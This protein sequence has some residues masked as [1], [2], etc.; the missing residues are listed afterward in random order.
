MENVNCVLCP[1][2]KYLV[3]A[4]VCM[5]SVLKNANIKAKVRFFIL[6][7]ELEKE[8]IKL[9]NELKKIRECEINIINVTEYFGY[10]K[11]VDFTDAL[12]YLKGN[13]ETLYRLLIWKI[14]PKDVEK[15]FYLDS[16]LLVNCD[17]LEVSKK[18]P[19]DKLIAAVEDIYVITVGKDIFVKQFP[20]YEKTEEFKNFAGDVKGYN[21]FG[22][23]FLLVNLKLGTEMQIFEE[24]VKYLNKYPNIA[25]M[26]QDVLNI[27]FS[28]N[29]KDKV[30]WLDIKYNYHV[31]CNITVMRSKN[32]ALTLEKTKVIHFAG[33]SKPW[34]IG[35]M[36][37]KEKDYLHQY[38]REWFKYLKVSPL[39]NKYNYYASKK[40]I[41]EKKK[42][43]ILKVN[44]LGISGFL[45]V[46]EIERLGIIKTRYYLF[47]FVP[48]FKVKQKGNT[49]S[50]YLM[51]LRF[52]KIK[53]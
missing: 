22:A 18:L 53:C 17:L 2:K 36:E 43:D 39:R 44:F 3:G 11:N 28:Q 34:V 51:G 5:T 52:F 32:L 35:N 33:D 41:I 10:F 48:V 19:E 50:Y 27:V 31:D 40:L 1:N 12:N 13:Y 9:I 7:T 47:N 4:I 14:I 38:Y 20:H 42:K 37:D 26:D 45:R 6:H 8:D 15:C 46:K 49:K 29:N 16:D 25:L 23:G 24:L 21:Y 30:E